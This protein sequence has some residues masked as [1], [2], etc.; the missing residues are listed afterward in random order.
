MHAY[1]LGS[2]GPEMV[3]P[4]S[5]A[6]AGGRPLREVLDAATLAAITERTRD[7]G[8]EVV[9]L[10]QT[11]SAYFAPGQSAALMVTTMARGD[12]TVLAVAV[13]PRGEYGL[14]DTRVGLPVRLG[15]RGLR[16]IVILPLEPAELAALTEAADRLGERIR[17]VS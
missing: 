10:L 12:D 4:L 9:K 13:E 3:V 17:E 1:A 8:A 14:R 16:E 15:P 11:G 2:H 5:Q 6:T 7:S